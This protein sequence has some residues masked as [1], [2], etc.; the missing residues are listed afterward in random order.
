[1]DLTT[2][3]VKNVPNKTGVGG[4]KEHPENRNN[5]GRYPRKESTTYWY[6][7]F[8]SMSVKEFNDWEYNNPEDTRTMASDLAYS[9]FR[10]AKNDF[11]EYQDIINRVEGT[12][13]HTAVVKED[14]IEGVEVHIVG[15]HEDIKRVEM[16]RALEKVY[17]DNSEY[18]ALHTT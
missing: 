4:F 9:R 14:K 6:N 2:Q 15:S 17:G 7:T 3:Q 13:I 18:K 1:M 5:G 16:L 8:M 11:R 10:K 12:P